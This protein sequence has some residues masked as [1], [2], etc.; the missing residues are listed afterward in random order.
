MKKNLA[1]HS[2]VRLASLYIILS[3]LAF[4]AMQLFVKVTAG[5][6]NVFFQ[7][8]MRNIVIFLLSGLVIL[9]RGQSFKIRKK[10]KLLLLRCIAGFLGVICYFYAT[11]ILNLA[12]AS[13][14]HKSSP[15]FIVVL[16]AI[17]YR[18]RINTKTLLIVCLAFIG[19][20][21]IIKPN[22]VLAPIPTVA[23]I[24]GAFFAAVAYVMIS[25]IGKDIDSLVI[26][27][28][29]SLF[30]SIAC[31]IFGW[32]SFVVPNS[33]DILPLLA[34]GIG[35]GLG[36]LFI[37]LGY[38]LTNA[39][40]ISVYNFTTIIFSALLGYFIYGEKIDGL[41]MLGICIIIA[42]AI[43]T[44]ILNNKEDIKKGRLG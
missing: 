5:N 39:E 36:Q 18:R 40:K 19:V 1:S 11:K 4:A 6:Y 44:H 35:G 29:F 13:A 25:L 41:S 7:T 20:L 17:I 34:I 12:D 30:S 3:S 8:F 24:A 32:E 2:N 22:F 14:L 31:I 10:K 28:Y 23:A 15:F 38:Q 26:I 9:T 21:L 43:M 42:A 16:T 27:F 37:T 33:Q